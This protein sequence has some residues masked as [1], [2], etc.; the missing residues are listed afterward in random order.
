MPKLAIFPI[1]MKVDGKSVLIVG[2]AEEAINK[3]RLLVKT[4]AN[5][6]VVSAEACEIVSEFTAIG[7]QTEHRA[8]ELADFEHAVM[9]FV[10]TENEGEQA[11]AIEM[12]T[13]T[14][15]LLN[16]VDVP[17]LCEFYTPAIVDRAPI[18]VAISSEGA[19]PVLSRFIRA[20]V[21]ALLSPNTGAIS[22]LAG[23]LRDKVESLISDG[24]AR[25]RFYE[26]LM[27]SAAVDQAFKTG[28]DAARYEA[29]KL[30]DA[31]AGRSAETCLVSLVG[32]GPGAEDLLTLRAQRV[33]QE[34]D[35]IVYDQLVPDLVVQMGRR[36]AQRICVGKSKGNHSVKQNEINAL[37]VEL[38]KENQNIVRLKSGDPMVF[39]RAHEEL[40]AL[41][42]HN[43]RYQI[44]PGVTA[45]LAAAADTATPL[46]L[47][48]VSSGVVFATAHGADDAELA[49]WAGLANA[50]IT[51]GIY[52]SKSIIEKTASA[53]VGEGLSKD[54][55]IGIVVNAGR[56]TQQNILSTL[57]NVAQC[58]D[59][60]I[61][62]PALILVGASIAEG[63]WNVFD[64]DKLD[65]QTDEK[66]GDLK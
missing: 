55:P 47:R 58:S 19:A 36:D 60:L 51:L 40:E 16:V 44:V 43:I 37:L 39:G 31:H 57:G 52:M 34:A 54:L 56:E 64:L 59:H 27:R 49:H 2:S 33:L 6:K 11:A 42:A 14:G 13:Q 46:T 1:S 48:N 18:S 65:K 4:S 50:G 9:V 3:A 28:T 25:R 30:L 17:H 29:F 12:A 61:E 15:T 23:S 66:L 10:A 38:S 53:L 5:I 20:K 63:D 22:G 45:T 24:D 26:N 35:V 62:G 8:P 32:A 21:E 7:L 41:R